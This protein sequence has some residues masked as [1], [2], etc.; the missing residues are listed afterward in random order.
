[1][2][3]V[4]ELEPGVE[5]A[6]RKKANGKGSSVTVYVQN[7]IKKDIEPSYEEVME[8]VWKAFEES[9]M[10][11]DDLDEFMNEIRNEVWNE[12]KNRSEK[13]GDAR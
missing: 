2:S 4:V 9:G 12:R 8:P 10:S 1:M 6:L 13:S 5:E 7:L 3:L 11:E